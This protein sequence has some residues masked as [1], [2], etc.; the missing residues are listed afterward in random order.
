M[1]FCYRLPS[2]AE[3]VEDIGGGS[4]D[5][6]VIQAMVVSSSDGDGS[7]NDTRGVIAA[8]VVG[9][10]V[11]MNSCFSGTEGCQEIVRITMK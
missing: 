2:Y 7:E 3:V 11:I 1:Y 9:N 4:G 8:V 6:N 10:N 5:G